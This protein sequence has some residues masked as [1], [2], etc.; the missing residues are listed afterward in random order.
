MEH[1]LLADTLLSTMK[2]YIDRISI[3]LVTR[4]MISSGI[5]VLK[6]R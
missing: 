3:H 1:W 2:K 4:G 6:D 5:R